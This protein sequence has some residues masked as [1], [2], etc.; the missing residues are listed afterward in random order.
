MLVHL[1]HLH[2][3]LPVWRP[4][5]VTCPEA[6]LLSNHAPLP[7]PLPQPRPAPSRQPLDQPK[8]SSWKTLVLGLGR[9]HQQNQA[10][11]VSYL[12]RISVL[13]VLTRRRYPPRAPS[14]L[15]LAHGTPLPLLNLGKHGTNT[16]LKNLMKLSTT[17][18][19]A[20]VAIMHSQVANVEEQS[21]FA[22][23]TLSSLSLL[24]ASSRSR[25]VYLESSCP[26][27]H[28]YSAV[29]SCQ[30]VCSRSYSHAL[31]SLLL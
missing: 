1:P 7:L 3:P 20:F 13:F 9:R 25:F 17:I 31:S 18:S 28:C 14:A 23:R 11:C 12:P 10:E 22:L 27:S 6:K 16:V 29:E 30:N 21:S 19:D 2:L 15:S 8:R 24:S 26:V 4:E 5:A